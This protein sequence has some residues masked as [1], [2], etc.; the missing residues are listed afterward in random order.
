MSQPDPTFDVI[1]IGMGPVGCLAT[2]LLAQY[3]IRVAAVEKDTEVYKLP[4]AV[5]LDGEIIRAFQPHGTADELFDL[6]QKVRPGD[7]SGFADSKRN[8][9]FGREVSDFSASGWQTIHMFDQPQL[10]SY[11]RTLALD[12]P[13]VASFVG[14]IADNVRQSDD[15]VHIDVTSEDVSETLSAP[16]LI[17]CDG[18]SSTIRKVLN[19]EWQDLG[20]DQDWLVVDVEVLPG[21]TLKNETLQVCDPDRIHTHVCTKDPYRRWEFRLNEGETW[22]EML[23]EEKILSL[24]DP[25]TPTETYKIRRAAMYQFHAGTA[26]TWQVGR[27][28]IAGDAAH[29]TPPFLG[30]GMNTGMRDV[31]NLAWKLPLVL[32]GEV[33]AS[34][35]ETYEAER[36]AHAHDFV[37]WAVSIGR[38][39]EHLADVEAATRA[40]KEPPEV[41]EDLQASG[42]GQ[43]RD[44]PPL[45]DG[46]IVQTQVDKSAL[47]GSLYRQPIVRD[48]DGERRFDEVLGPGFALVTPSL[49]ALGLSDASKQRLRRLSIRIVALDE[50]ELVRGT[51][52]DH[53]HTTIVRPDRYIFGHTDTDIDTDK[54]IEL[55]GEKLHLT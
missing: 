7:R 12:Q 47:T 23:E 45:R 40:G 53:S 29:Q 33:D 52:S 42:Y 44:A 35:L 5:A 39:M 22:E 37:D 16:W 19:I 8:W 27:V 14:C 4:R 3:G 25:W 26:K 51:Y 6:L 32:N 46:V 13:S 36:V 55:L 49:S 38:L 34:L 9:L 17:A 10:E 20:Y 11:L 24:I 21:H 18:A 41:P 31:I 43:G 2:Y 15:R 48:A 50:H 30:Q 28:L 1:I 54:L